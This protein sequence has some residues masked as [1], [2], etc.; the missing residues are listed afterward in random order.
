MVCFDIGHLYSVVRI[1]DCVPLSGQ[2]RVI[3]IKQ[4]QDFIDPFKYYV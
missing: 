4:D 3:R 2:I 1:T